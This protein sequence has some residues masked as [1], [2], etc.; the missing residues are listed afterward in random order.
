MGRDS[1]SFQVRGAG[2]LER[3][4]AA[5]NEGVTSGK[6]LSPQLGLVWFKKDAQLNCH[7]LGDPAPQEWPVLSQ[8]LP[9]LSL[10]SCW[11]VTRQP[12]LGLLMIGSRLL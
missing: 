10:A 1:K 2:V 8:H 12:Q 11:L 5:G 7:L 4:G 6:A 3:K 9:E